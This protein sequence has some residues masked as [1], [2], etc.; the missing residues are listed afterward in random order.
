MAKS[1]NT[2]VVSGFPGVGKSFFIS[3]DNVL[4]DKLA[5]LDSDSSKF[6]K[7]EF[8]S[9]Y[10]DKVKDDIGSYH[11]IFVSSHK[12][13][14]NALV[15]RK[16][17]FILVY[18]DVKSKEEYLQRYR[19]RGSS[20]DFINNVDANWEEWLK[21]MKKQKGCKHIVLKEGEYLTDIKLLEENKAK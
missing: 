21:D 9:N 4:P 1:K 16:I 13:V 15:E 18:P 10:V 3:Q 12:E 19:K 14:R 11:I 2:V 5:A 6:K 8:P 17:P 20:E 7:T